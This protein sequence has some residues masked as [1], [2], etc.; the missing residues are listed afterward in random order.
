MRTNEAEEGE[1]DAV[2]QDAPAAP[3]SSLLF[4]SSLLVMDDVQLAAPLLALLRDDWLHPSL[5][6][7]LL[8][9]SLI[10]SPSSPS[11]P[12]PSFL[13]MLPAF[14]ALSVVRSVLGCDGTTHDADGNAAAPAVVAARV[15]LPPANAG[16]A[17]AAFSP[18]PDTLRGWRT[19]W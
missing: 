17:V 15:F 11:S 3:S 16:G 2:S 19:A 5:S 9:A 10:A 6:L 1:D 18:S 7:S 8:A 13:V 14:K 12:R 4:P